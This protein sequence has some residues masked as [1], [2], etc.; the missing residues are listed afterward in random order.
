M[1]SLIKFLF[2]MCLLLIPTM[3]LASESYY[4]RL[5]CEKHNGEVESII[6]GNLVVECMTEDMVIETCYAKN[7]YSSLLVKVLYYSMLTHKKAGLLLIV[8]NSSE[9]NYV[10][11]LQRIIDYHK[12]PVTLYYIESETYK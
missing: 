2:C 10:D 8:N 7:I 3:L 11:R 1:K 5:W 12:L 6:R 4:N 9:W